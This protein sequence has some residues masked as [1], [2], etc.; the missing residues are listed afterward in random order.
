M[1]EKITLC[2][3]ENKH[4]PLFYKWWNDR[5]LR[6]LTSKNYDKIDEEKINEILKKH[7]LDKSYHDFIIIAHEDKPIGH[8]LIQK[9]KNKKYYELYIAIGEKDYWS[10]GYGTRAIKSVGKWFFKKFSNEQCLDIEVHSDNLRAKK[11]YE[12]SGFKFIKIRKYK[13][14]P[15]THLMRKFRD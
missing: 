10:K 1:N 3:L 2:K 5:E 9:G 8:I 15:N 13:K 11:C 4:F 6:D 12:K 14:Y 7:L